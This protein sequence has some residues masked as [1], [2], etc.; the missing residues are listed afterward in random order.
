ME[1]IEIYCCWGKNYKFWS[2][3]WPLMYSY[4]KFIAKSEKHLFDST[5]KT[6][7]QCNNGASIC[8]RVFTPSNHINSL[9]PVNM[10]AICYQTIRSVGGLA[11]QD[12]ASALFYRSEVWSPHS[13]HPPW[14][15]VEHLSAC[16]VH[17]RSQDSSYRGRPLAGSPLLWRR[18]LPEV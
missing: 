9:L 18:P 17:L 4:N 5:S 6:S 11:G 10:S 16:S 8:S 14:L 15:H 7:I 3:S 2:V 1:Y 12:C 13:S